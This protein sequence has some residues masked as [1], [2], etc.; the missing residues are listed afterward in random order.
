MIRYNKYNVVT[1]SG[2][3]NCPNCNYE[4]TEQL[5]YVIEPFQCKS[6]KHALGFI[7]LYA[8]DKT[9]YTIDLD[10]SSGL[11]KSMFEYLYSKSP[12]ETHEELKDL[13]MMIN[14]QV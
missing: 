5:I 1:K 10:S 3:L 4:Y 6:C 12:K 2:S 11:I 14:K 9:I 8:V 13:I 7:R